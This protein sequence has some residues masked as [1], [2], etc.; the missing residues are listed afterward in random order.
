MEDVRQMDIKRNK[1]TL[2]VTITQEVSEVLERLT[3]IYGSSKSAI[4]SIA[5]V[6]FAKKQGLDL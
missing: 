6:D 1:E 4:V 3:K 2:S 5:L